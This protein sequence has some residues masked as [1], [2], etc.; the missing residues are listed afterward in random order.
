M[1][2]KNK[3]KTTAKVIGVLGAKGG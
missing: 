3:A 1:L 2:S